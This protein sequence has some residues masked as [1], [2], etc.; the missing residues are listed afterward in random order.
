MQGLGYALTEELLQ[1]DG[2]LLTNTL[3]TYIAPL[4]ID[5]PEIE[6][7]I[8]EVP[9]PSAPN[10]A[11]GV[12]EPTLIPVAPA[13]ANAIADAVGVRVQQIPMTPERVLNSMKE[14]LPAW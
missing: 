4:S 7:L 1:E 12:G 9:Q 5:I 13:I 11:I 6:H 14:E 3:A 10:G 2:E 8:I